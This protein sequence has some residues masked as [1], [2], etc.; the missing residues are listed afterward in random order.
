[1]RSLK[2]Q[3]YYFF[4]AFCFR[5]ARE[6]FHFSLVFHVMRGFEKD[7]AQF[8]RL[9]QRSETYGSRAI[10]ASFGYNRDM[11]FFR[12]NLDFYKNTD[13]KYVALMMHLA[14]KLPDLLFKLFNWIVI[15]NWVVRIRLYLVYNW[16]YQHISFALFSRYVCSFIHT[17]Y[18]LNA[19]SLTQA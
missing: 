8:N 18:C 17:Y 13:K 3:S 16:N 14:Q 6:N 4:I 12:C 11:T 2:R 19:I 7:M 15:C 1:M 10:Y 9:S 5:D